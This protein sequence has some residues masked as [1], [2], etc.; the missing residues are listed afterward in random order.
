[1]RLRNERIER[2]VS[3]KLTNDAT[4]KECKGHHPGDYNQDCSMYISKYT[5]VFTETRK[6]EEAA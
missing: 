6:I 3:R 2:I 1:M 5:Y 4:Y